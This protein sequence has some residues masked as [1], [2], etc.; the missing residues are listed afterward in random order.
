VTAVTTVTV[1]DEW[2]VTCR[3]NDVMAQL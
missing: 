3:L 2:T 1:H